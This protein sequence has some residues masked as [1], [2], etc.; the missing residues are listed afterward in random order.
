MAI[1]SELRECGILSA[2]GNTPLVHLARICGEADFRLYAKI[3]SCNPGG[4][5]KDR[6]AFNI[7]K[8]AIEDGLIESGST[9]VES[10]SGNMAI[11]LAQACLY[12]NMRFICVI[13]PKTT[14]PNIRLLLAYGA[15]V[16]MVEDPDPESGE[17]LPARIK[18]VQ[19][20]LRQIEGSYWP[21][22]YS[23]LNNSRAHYQTMREIAA[24]L[25][26]QVDYLFCSTS[27]CGTLR[28]CSEFIRRHSLRTR[29]IAV[30]A[31]GSVIF[32]TDHG[33]RLIPG[34]G[35]AIVPDLYRPGLADEFIQVDDVDC[36]VGC[37][38]LLRREAILAGGSSGAV[39]MA[40]ERTKDRIAK[41]SNCVAICADRG[42]RYLDTIY[43]D[44]WVTQTFGDI[45][46]LWND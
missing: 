43:S 29:I 4:S 36:I 22:Q 21:N 27:T 17:F 24:Q 8:R 32:G 23:N 42:E 1:S 26:N 15:K 11:G 5:L 28:G 12:Y 14:A 33:K 45:S 46:E 9:I 44:N 37:R 38:R 16:D 34:H 25:D 10:S 41:G 18:R 35:A 7:V 39:M 2:I 20:L 19:S 6:P 30:D 3:E 13:D 40:V 31:V